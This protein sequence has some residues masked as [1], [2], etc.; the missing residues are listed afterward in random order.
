MEGNNQKGNPMERICPNCR[1]RI[2][3]EDINVS[4]DIALCRVCGSSFSFLLLER[5]CPVS[6]FSEMECPRHIRIEEDFGQKVIV[7]RRIWPVV[8]VLIPFVFFWSGLSMWGLYIQPLMQ[9]PIDWGRM[10]FGI[11]FLLGTIMLIAMILFGLFGK[12]VITL[13]NGQGTV[14]V[15]IGPLGRTRTFSYSRDSF[16]MLKDSNFRRDDVPIQGICI[17]NGQEEFCFGTL[18]DLKSQVYLAAL[19]AVEA[20]KL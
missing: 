10:L 7:Y 8:W 18:I 15:G 6:D 13:E 19:I 14:F 1:S 11:P 2:A 5:A 9:D 16:I 17:R 3:T 12:V 20:A 4:K